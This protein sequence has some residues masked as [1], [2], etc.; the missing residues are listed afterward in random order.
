MSDA[1]RYD[2]A[3]A[4]AGPAGAT[5]AWYLARRGIRVLLLEKK[6]FPRD[7]LCGDAICGR[8]LVH[9]SRMGVLQQILDDDEGHPAA[10]GGMVSPRGISYVGSSIE[11]LE[12]PAVIAVK[13]VF[14]DVRIAR[15]A[16][17][18]GA[19]L[20]ERYSVADARF[21][22]GRGEWSILPDGLGPTYRARILVAADGALSRLARRL[23]FVDCPPDALCSRTYMRA[24]TTNFDA[25]GVVF[26]PREIL[27]GYCALFREARGDLNFAMYLIPGGAC[28][29]RDLRSLHDRLL[30]DDPHVSKAVGPAA[31]IDAMKGAPLRLGGIG[32]SHGDHLLILG[33]AAGQI[34]PLTG[35]GIQ[36]AMD[37]AEI[38]AQSLG[39]ALAENDLR[40]SSLKRYDDRWRRAFGHDFVWSARF[41]RFY[42]R[43]P[44]FLDAAAMTLNRR[45]DA[46]LAQWA[47]IMTGARPKRDFLKPRMLLPV[48]GDLWRREWLRSGPLRTAA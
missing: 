24:G 29:L 4:G 26:Y 2:V 43:C 8:A 28:E 12:G 18:A 15:A 3:I 6:S 47:E 33:D 25:D 11:H 40:E 32:K 38:A 36:Y 19:E 27:P 34:D 16:A 39:E 44:S 23:G 17:A 1:D 20:V 41:A 22:A 10:V 42:L 7:K 5:C 48:L 37:A 35:E 31:E 46:Y 45:G 21:D 30:R 14:L 13:R 9:L